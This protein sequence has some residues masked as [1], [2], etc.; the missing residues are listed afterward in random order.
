MLISCIVA[1]SLPQRAIGQ[2]NQLPW[3]LPQDLQWFK[4]HTLGKTL[5]FGRKTQASIGRVL[6]QRQTWLLSRQ[7]QNNPWN[8]PQFQD[9]DSLIKAAQQAQIPEL[10]IAG[11]AEIYQLALPFCQK[12]YLTEIQAFFPQAD[13]FFPNWQAELWTSCYEEQG[14]E[15]HYRFRILEKKSSTLFA[16]D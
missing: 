7:N 8:L 9:W 5:V 4:R 6:P 10:M 11:G 13:V 12:I 14:Q 16:K 1:Y 15:S 2:N 3:H